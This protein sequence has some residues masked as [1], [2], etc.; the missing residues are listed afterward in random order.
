MIATYTPVIDLLQR[1]KDSFNPTV[2]SRACA[3]FH[4][5]E[6]STRRAVDHLL[7]SL[8][9]AFVRHGRTTYAGQPTGLI[10][11]CAEVSSPQI[12][13][14][15]PT[16]LPNAFSAPPVIERMI[17]AGIA[18]ARAVLPDGPER[19]ANAVTDRE[20]ISRLTS[21][22]LVGLLT[23]TLCSVLKT[24]ILQQGDPAQALARALDHASVSHPP[25]LP[26]AAAAGSQ[27]TVKRKQG[28][29]FATLLLVSLATLGLL[30]FAMSHMRQVSPGTQAAV[31]KSEAATLS[32]VT[33]D[34]GRP[35]VHAR[36]DTPEHKQQL[37]QAL[38]STF[39]A[40]AYDADIVVEPGTSA[41]TWWDKL[42]AMLAALHK[43]NMDVSIQGQAVQLAGSSADGESG[44]RDQLAAL[45]GDGFSWS[46][47]KASE[48][49]AAANNALH[50]ALTALNPGTCTAPEVV[51][52]LNT[53]SINFDS[54]TSEL[55]QAELEVLA[56]AAKSI[57]D[58]AKG[59]R[60]EILGHTDSF[61]PTQVNLSLSRQR[62]EAVR[63]FLVEHGVDANTLEVHG[64]GSA[65]P[66]AD[67]E[68]PAGRYE[69]RR[70]EF[71]V[72]QQ[73]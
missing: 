50:D 48:A 9:G 69:N 7:P 49:L 22:A 20:G 42:T 1:A 5:S 32:F 59:A 61:G 64:Y 62:A 40:N 34:Q 4:S 14:H 53:H 44:L 25:S 31:D 43:P 24:H 10:A 15:F 41:P 70:I 72:L 39:G 19:L 3:Y 54:G 71:A 35:T 17:A 58:C 33:D 36:L 38:D 45:F 67:N 60:L 65:R 27:A 66:I 23:L 26:T 30:W 52:A 18:Q 57:S 51:R 37:L 21:L 12:D 73:Q 68:T 8:I 28:G 63:T 46:R 2:I 6:E 11:L 55:P 16:V 29:A 47:F 56:T 13:T